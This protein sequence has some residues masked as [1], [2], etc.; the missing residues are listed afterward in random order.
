L[1]PEFDENRDQRGGDEYTEPPSLR[2]ATHHPSWKTPPQ[3]R[4]GRHGPLAAHHGIFGRQRSRRSP[5]DAAP[6]LGRA[7][8]FSVKN[9]QSRYLLN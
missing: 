2:G 8:D 4:T 6:Q 7:E 5:R 9:D 1:R 3:R